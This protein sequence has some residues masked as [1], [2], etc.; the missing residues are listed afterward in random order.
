MVNRDV[1]A[2][3]IVDGLTALVGEAAILTGG[4]AAPYAKGARYG[5]GAALCVVRPA[6]AAQV[7]EVVKFCA[8]HAVS[9]VVQ[10]AN[11]GLVGAS[12]PDTSGR[13]VILSTARLNRVCT[14]D[15]GNR[16]VT[17]DAGKTLQELNDALAPHAFWFPIDLG[18]NP[19][20]GGMIGAN[21]GGTRLIR[22]GDVRH[23]LLSLDVVLFDPPGQQLTLGR[24]LRKDNTGFDLKQLFVGTSGVCGV[25]T[26]AT[27]EIHPRPQQSATA[28]VVPTSDA[29]VMQLLTALETELGDFLSAFEGM[30]ANA[31]QVAVDHIPNARNPFAPEPMPEFAILI[32]LESSCSTAATGL[33]LVQTLNRFLESKLESLISNAV[34]GNAKDLWRVRHGITEGARKVGKPIAFDVSVPRSRIMEFRQRATDIVTKDFPYLTVIDFGHIADGGVHFNLVW[35]HAARPAYDAVVVSD[36]RDRIYALVVEQFGGS[37]S[38]EHGV[39]PHNATYYQ[40][41]TDGDVKRIAGVIKNT[42]DPAGLCGSVDYGP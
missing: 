1:E 27:L 3:R 42:L 8:T 40:R 36:L 41:Y 19:M 26:R 10:G 11:T 25:I 34:I 6:S 38:A 2:Q 17:V 24:P 37:Y 12:S 32:E 18:A 5:D 7:S 16:S 22:Y 33:D 13:Q 15:V 35:P 14:V 4:D 28:L 20:I 30:S 39:G 29:A 23:N 9:I 21:T 31:I